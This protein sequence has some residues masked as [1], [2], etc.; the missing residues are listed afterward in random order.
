MQPHVG[1]VVSFSLRVNKCV[2]KLFSSDS[3]QSRRWKENL[4]AVFE[5]TP[6]NFLK[7]VV[8]VLRCAGYFVMR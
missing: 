3:G 5:P 2:A 4:S 1:Q 6:G 7:Y 8:S